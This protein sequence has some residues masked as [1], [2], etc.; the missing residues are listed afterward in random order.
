M[1]VKTGQYHC[2]SY[3]A[4]IFLLIPLSFG[5]LAGGENILQSQTSALSQNSKNF[6]QIYQGEQNL[7]LNFLWRRRTV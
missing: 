5:P 1:A 6:A 4:W 2:K 3:Y 7:L